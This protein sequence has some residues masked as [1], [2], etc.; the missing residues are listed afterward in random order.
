MVELWRMGPHPQGQW[1]TDWDGNG[2]VVDDVLYV[3][4]EDSFF[5]VV[6]L[7]R[8]IGADG[9]VSVD[10]EVLLATP[11]FD[12]E[13]NT[14]A[15]TR[16][17]SIEASVVVADEAVFVSNSGG[18]ILG[19]DRGAEEIRERVEPYIDRAKYATT[20]AYERAKQRA[21]ELAEEARPYAERARTATTQAAERVR[22]AATQAAE[23][24][25]EA[26]SRP[27]RSWEASSIGEPSPGAAAG[28]GTVSHKSPASRYGR[29][30]RRER[31]GVAFGAGFT[32]T[33][34]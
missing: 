9:L 33:R 25:R 15:G 12:A 16:E 5:Y 34:G 6:E 18:R 8:R 30:G 22:S 27:V 7:H 24:V 3:G 1:N 23:K 11:T 29:C 4:G 10:P 20:Q 26:T 28:S 32:L 19:F 17:T 13:F 2:S 31:A 14:L 21:R